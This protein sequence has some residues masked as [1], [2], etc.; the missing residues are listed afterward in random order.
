MAQMASMQVASS[1]FD[2]WFS[3]TSL[4][5]LS[6]YLVIAV[7]VSLPW[8]TSITSIL[9]I[10]W[11]LALI[12]TLEP[13]ELRRELLAPAGGLPVLLWLLAAVGMLWA[14]VT[15]A[16]R[17]YGLRYYHKLL[18]IPLLL[19]QFRRSNVGWHVLA[20]FCVSCTALLIVSWILKL[21]PSLSWSI[22]RPPGV[23]VKDRIVQATEFLICAAVLTHVVINLWT[24]QRRGLA[25][26]VGMVT[27]GFLA[28]I[29]FVSLART[30]LV[31]GP[32]LVI[33]IGLQRF[34]ARSA[35]GLVATGVLFAGA[36]WA[37]S[38][39]LRERVVSAFQEIG[40]FR[41]N[42]VTSA[43]LRLEFWRQ[44]LGL[45]ADAPLAGHGTG[46]TRALSLEIVREERATQLTAMPHNPHNQTLAIG[47]QLGIAGIVLVFA[48]WFT[49][50]ELF[51]GSGLACWIGT[52][53]V[54]QNILASLFNSHLFDF[55]PGWIYVLGVGVLGGLVTGPQAHEDPL[56]PNEPERL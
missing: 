19:I 48:L 20:G 53:L 46:S 43:G 52:L 31:V 10:L 56:A 55:T 26:A 21:W 32:C 42:P 44:S 34:G 17:L 36:I 3:A 7:A 41:D 2:P 1:R 40:Q 25:V 27:L 4:R 22:D 6:D 15:W 13:A 28:N 49:H 9:L 45:M 51:R 5:R 23:P 33:L 50:L 8:S 39:D 18:A 16:D 30:A 47:I 14:D 11:L 35:V 37:T 24:A 54:A 38:P 29:G 12:P